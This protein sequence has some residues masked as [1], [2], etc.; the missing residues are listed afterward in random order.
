MEFHA[1]DPI[2]LT[3]AEVVAADRVF[4]GWIAV[5]SGRIVEIGEGGGPKGAIDCQGDYLLPGLVELHTDHLEAHF[6]PR[7]R[8]FWHAGSAVMAYDAQ[9]AAAGITTVFDSFRLGVDEHEDWRS[10]AGEQ[11][12]T[13]VEAI[14]RARAADLLRAD[15]QTHLRCEVPS[16][17]VVE[18]LEDFLARH[19]ARLVSLMDHTPGQRQFRDLEK[20]FIYYQGKT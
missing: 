5:E 1:A 14:E 20:Y 18:A 3:N 2:V 8:V 11:V 10:G 7:P 12:A 9:I 16:P 4:P 15:H 19:P 17:N 13:L 6:M